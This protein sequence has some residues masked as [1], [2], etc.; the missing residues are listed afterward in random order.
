MKTTKYFYLALTGLM[1]GGSDPAIAASSPE[2]KAWIGDTHGHSSLSSDAFGF[3][4]RLTPD[5]GCS[6]SGPDAGVKS[7]FRFG[8]ERKSKLTGN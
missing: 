8:N 4:N 6:D 7:L 5:S 1:V 2:R 3:G